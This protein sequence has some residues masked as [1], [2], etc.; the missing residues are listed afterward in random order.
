MKNLTVNEV[1]K[2]ANVS[3]ATALQIVEGFLDTKKI[4]TERGEFAKYAVHFF[5]NKF[6]ATWVEGNNAPK[7]GRRGEFVIMVSYNESYNEFAQKLIE[8]DDAKGYMRKELEEK[9][10]VAIAAMNIEDDERIKFVS[11]T[12]N[13]STTQ[14]KKTAHNFAARKLGFYSVEGR[15]KFLQLL[16][17]SKQ[18]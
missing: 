12:S 2:I 10:K 14:A 6:N 15:D 4:Y 13:M 1:M 8:A 3:H 7:G 9:R 17:T 5:T 16:K 11:I 18:N